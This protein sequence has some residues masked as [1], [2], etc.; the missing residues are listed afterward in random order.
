MGYVCSRS[1][2]VQ[3]P[4]VTPM[5]CDSQAFCLKHAASYDQNGALAGQSCCPLS[6]LIGQFVPFAPNFSRL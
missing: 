6:D 2:P 1:L 4:F 3:Q 5:H